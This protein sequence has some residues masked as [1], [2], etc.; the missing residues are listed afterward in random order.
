MC[1]E[2]GKSLGG[3]SFRLACQDGNEAALLPAILK[4]DDAGD[5]SKEG[6][7]LAA[8]DVQAGLEWGAALADQDGSAGDSFAAK[9][10]DAEPLCV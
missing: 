7:I 8:A 10:L 9:A 6:V 3:G 4:L 1:A 2:A 5:L